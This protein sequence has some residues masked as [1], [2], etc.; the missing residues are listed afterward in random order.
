MK[1]ILSIAVAAIMLTVCMT[2]ACHATAEQAPHFLPGTYESTV[3]GL[4]SK[5][6]VSVTFSE[7][8]IEDIVILDHAESR[9]IAQPALDRVPAAILEKQSL[10]VDTVSSCTMTSI[11]V[12]NAV[13]ECV[14]QAGV[15]PQTLYIPTE[16]PEK[17]DITLDCDIVVVGAGMA[18]LSAALEA[19]D[20]G[21]QVVLLEKLAVSGGS[22]ALS[23]GVIDIIGLE[24]QKPLGLTASPADFVEIWNKDDALREVTAKNPDIDYEK[25]RLFIFEKSV[26]AY[27][28]LTKHGDILV[29]TPYAGGVWGDQP[30][31]YY[32]ANRADLFDSYDAGGVEHT[33]ALT[34]SAE[35]D[36]HIT[37]LY[38]TPA[39][40]LI[41]KD[42]RVAGVVAQSRTGTVTVNAGHVVL[43]TGGFAQNGEMTHRFNDMLS[44]DFAIYSCASV[45]CTGDGITMAEAVGADVYDHAFTKTLGFPVKPGFVHADINQLKGMIFIDGNGNR[46]ASNDGYMH[47]KPT[48]ITQF[49]TAYQETGRIYDIFDADTTGVDVLEANLANSRVFKA[50]TLEELA[51]MIRISPEALKK[52]VNEFNAACEKG[53]DE[54]FGQTTLE[55]VDQSPFY[56]TQNSLSGFASFGGLVTNDKYQVLDTN[57][58]P[59]SGLYAAGELVLGK[60]VHE[61][62]APSISLLN[63]TVSGMYAVKNALAE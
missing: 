41:V 43:A 55:K 23:G 7:S 50:D 47:A 14:K 29:D 42:G 51:E 21:A 26:E 59:I 17:K 33:Y 10:A 19:A 63:C 48:F 37:I 57:G 46:F 27:H 34:V 28:F 12:R 56:A 1:K 54:A 60:L 24:E 58:Q 20:E 45:G 18:G 39:T 49:A 35:A 5:I 31:Q 62:Y 11:A 32:S 16:Q 2:F 38:E 4:R 3:D 6:T 9:I 53:I 13:S 15:D 61:N 40:E 36:D 30:I 22:S 8:R 52:T 25:N 44:S